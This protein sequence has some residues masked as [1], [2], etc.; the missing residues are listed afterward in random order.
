MV[1]RTNND[2]AQKNDKI[3]LESSANANQFEN[4]GCWWP[5]IAR[6]FTSL[7]IGIARINRNL[8]RVDQTIERNNKGLCQCFYAV[9]SCQEQTA[10]VL[11][12]EMDRHALNPAVESVVSLADELLRLEQ[13]GRE[14]SIQAGSDPQ[15]KRLLEELTISSQIA[16]NKLAYLDIVKITAMKGEVFNAQ[17]HT[18]AAC[19]ITDDSVLHGKISEMIMAGI[20]YRG[21]ILKHARVAIFKYEQRGVNTE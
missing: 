14:L 3:L 5:F 16:H 8:R 7:K 15:I 2:V 21:K 9:K 1:D 13:L 17:I 19:Q 10:K 4:L 18:I 6:R 11:N 20:V 12:N